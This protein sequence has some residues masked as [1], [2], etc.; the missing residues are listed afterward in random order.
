M[1][2]LKHYFIIIL[3]LFFLFSGRPAQAENDARGLPKLLIFFSPGCHRC[4]VVKAQ[5]MPGIENE[6]RGRVFFEYLNLDNLDNYRLWLSLKD[7]TQPGI[8]FEI[9]LFYLNGSFINSE[10]DVRDKLRMFIFEGIKKQNEKRAGAHINL[11]EY[12]KHLAPLAVIIAGL[13]DGFNPC[14]FTVIVFF[15]SFLAFQGY[16]KKELFLIGAVFIFAVFFT[17]L[18][19]GLGIFNFLY[20]IRNFW[21]L[22]RAINLLVGAS[23]IGLGLFSLYDY[24]KFRRTADT[25]GLTLQLPQAIKNRIHAIIGFYY[26]RDKNREDTLK[27]RIYRLILSAL[28]TGFLVCLLEAVC[29]GQ[30]YLP[31][32]VFIFKNTSLKVHALSYILLYNTMFVIP[33]IIIFILALAGFTSSDFAKFTKKHLGL[34][35]ILMAA[36]FFTLGILLIRRG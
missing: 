3:A 4:Q 34:I 13:Q 17:Y 26:R 11:V 25:G 27:P 1:L 35:K 23:S 22:T 10:G 33:L 24:F 21:R 30:A 19:I 36:L 9:P 14:A 20:G 32:L 16:R 8:K 31:T 18:L 5:I 15:I 29:T 2:K 12:F 7:K 28:I 6:F